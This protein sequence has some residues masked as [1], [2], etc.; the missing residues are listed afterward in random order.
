VVLIQR[1]MLIKVGRS[2]FLLAIGKKRLGKPARLAKSRYQL[3]YNLQFPLH[4]RVMSWECAYI[5]VGTRLF[6]G[7]KIDGF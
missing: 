7:Y 3:F 1:I 2:F 5:L 6:R 4:Q